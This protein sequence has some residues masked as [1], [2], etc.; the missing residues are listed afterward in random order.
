MPTSYII[1]ELPW[2]PYSYGIKMIKK[3]FLKSPIFPAKISSTPTD[4]SAI[5]RKTLCPQSSGLWS[6]VLAGGEGTRTRPFIEAWLGRHLPKQYCTFTGTRSLFQHTLDRAHKLSP[7]KHTLVVIDQTH[8][9]FVEPQLAGRPSMRVIPQPRNCDTAPGIF[10]PL[11]YIRQTD[12]QATVIISPS[13]HFVYPESG[14][15][16]ILQA[17]VEETA[18]INRLILLGVAPDGLE[19]EYGWIQPGAVISENGCC[20]RS[21]RSFIEKPALAEARAAMEAGALWNTFVLVGKVEKLWELGWNYLPKMMPLFER[22]SDAVGSYREREVIRSIYESMPTLNFSSGLLQRA[23]DQVAVVKLKDIFW[24]DWGSPGRIIR[25]FGM[26]HRK[27]VFPSMHLAV[28]N[29]NLQ[30]AL[31]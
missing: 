10:L 21:V 6:I 31:K 28:P 29:W 15:I 25:T 19:L 14:Y 30:L 3:Y 17:A 11:S 22:L 5:S 12:P 7:D 18:Y 13:D 16:N 23:T 2:I 24:S 8:R 1:W 20:V 9:Q 27:P 4:Y 26:I